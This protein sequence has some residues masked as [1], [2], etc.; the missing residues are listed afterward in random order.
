[1]LFTTTYPAITAIINYG[2]EPEPT[3]TPTPS[4]EET[5]HPNVWP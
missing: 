2:P 3:P 4:Y 5:D 1:M